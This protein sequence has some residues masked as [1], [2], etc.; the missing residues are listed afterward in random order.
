VP[1]WF[2]AGLALDKQTIETRV[3]ARMERNFIL[4]VNLT[5]ASGKDGRVGICVERMSS[6]Y[7]HDI[8][9]R[10]VGDLPGQSNGRLSG[11]GTQLDTKAL[12][13]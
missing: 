5:F 11:E 3:M 1:W 12:F 13:I 7:W 4:R 8:E 6:A 10:D 9:G 2:G